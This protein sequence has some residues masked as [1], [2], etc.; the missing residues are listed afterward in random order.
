MDEHHE[1]SYIECLLKP[2]AQIRESGD[3]SIEN[4]HIEPLKDEAVYCLSSGTSGLPKAVRLSHYN[5]IANTIQMTVTLGGR[6]NKPVFDAANWYNQP[7]APPQNGEREVHY[8]L[9][10]QFHCYGLITAMICLH[11][12]TPSIIESKFHPEQFFRA[13]QQHKNDLSLQKL[14][15]GRLV[16]NTEAIVVD[17]NTGRKLGPNETGELWV[18]GPQMMLGYLHNDKANNET[19]VDALKDQKPFLRTGDVVSIDD[20]G[21]IT[22][23][24]RLKDIIKYNGYQV[25]ASEI[26][27]LVYSLPFVIDCAVVAKVVKEDV[28]NNELPWAFVVA[29]EGVDVSEQL[30]E[31][32]LQHVNERV[33]GFKKL[34]G[35]AW[36]DEL[37]RSAAGKILKRDLRARLSEE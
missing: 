16:S 35:V 15:V 9:L 11:T 18:R 22:I 7:N 30:T 12:L 28:A 3:K 20:Q 4:V 8:S 32:V 29:K 5:M 37:P 1:R 25:A 31:K 19:F 6:V 10:P 36:V 13:V 26:E 21:Y 27:Q 17:I 33:A 24:D 14:N 2:G 23:R 34:R